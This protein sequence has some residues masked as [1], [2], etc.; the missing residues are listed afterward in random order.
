MKRAFLFLVFIALIC[1][2][3]N[4]VFLLKDG[5]RI[6]GTFQNFEED[7]V[8]VETKY[9]GE[10]KIPWENIVS[11]QSSRNLYYR[12][13]NG[14]IVAAS[15]TTGS[16]DGQ[17][18]I[19]SPIAGNFV[20]NRNQVLMVGLT[21]ESVNPDF[22]QV[23]KELKEKEEALANATEIGRVW[24]G[25][26]QANFSGSTGNTDEAILNGIGHVERA[27]KHDKFTAQ[28]EGRYGKTDGEISHQ[29]ISGF[30]REN[31]NITERLY[32]YG[33]LEAKYDK[34]KEI[35]IQFVGELGLGVH[36][37]CENDFH[38][39][40]GDK[41]TLDWDL[42][43]TYT[44]TDYR[45]ADDSNSVGM[46]TRLLYNHIFPNGWK[47]YAAGAYIQDFE[48]PEHV[49]NAE[50]Y[51]GYRLKAEVML[52]IPITDILSFTASIK[53]EYNSEPAPGIERNDFYWLL[54]LKLSL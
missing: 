28:L 48:E 34:V 18:G 45:H 30:I 38:M 52:E 15:Q 31:V 24:S 25:Y 19:Q 42:G 29:E 46:V 7:H 3:A 5:D 39:F 17:F 13:E 44:A 9:L 41:I 8:I 23:Q 51:D 10:V 14:N 1:A 6:S 20:V 37:I 27:G 2:S 32:I 12:L 49:K 35:N 11:I 33:R 40:E 47:L 54:G 4:E 21:E 16:G 43:V 22:I 50:W 26:I 36:I 53:D